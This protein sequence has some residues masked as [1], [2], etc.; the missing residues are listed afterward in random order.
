MGGIDAVENFLLLCVNCHR[1]VHKDE[2]TA[3]AYGYISWVHPWATPVWHPRG[4]AGA[5]GWVLLVPDGSM[6]PIADDEAIRLL[7]YLGGLD[8]MQ[9]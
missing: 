9:A 7:G 2:P 8:R 5:P 1:Q 4:D 6:E 3:G